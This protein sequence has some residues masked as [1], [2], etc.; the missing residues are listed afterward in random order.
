MQ[1]SMS[2]PISGSDKMEQQANNTPSRMLNFKKFHIS[3]TDPCYQFRKSPANKGMKLGSVHEEF[4]QHGYR[5]QETIGV[6]GY[7]KVKLALDIKCNRKVTR[8]MVF[9]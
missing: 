3:D 2:Q 1:R 6:G 5:M 9:G 4:E 7:S 8:M